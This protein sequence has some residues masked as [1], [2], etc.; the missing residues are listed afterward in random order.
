MSLGP[1]LWQYIG[2]CHG[3]GRAAVAADNHAPVMALGAPL[4]R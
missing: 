3:A 1:K 2:A 4:W